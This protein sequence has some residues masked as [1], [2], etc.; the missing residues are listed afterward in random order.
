MEWMNMV[1]ASSVVKDIWFALQNRKVMNGFGKK[2]A[3]SV[4]T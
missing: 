4:T 1:D 3:H 2:D